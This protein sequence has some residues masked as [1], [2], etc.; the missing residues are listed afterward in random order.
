MESVSPPPE[1][2]DGNSLFLRFCKWCLSPW[3]WVQSG[4][5]G[6]SSCWCSVAGTWL[7]EAVGFPLSSV[8][9]GLPFLIQLPAS[10]ILLI[11]FCGRLKPQSSLHTHNC[12][13]FC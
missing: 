4:H 3:L 8:T 12:S 7:E 1:L 2:Q 6:Q 9:Q 11:Y 13:E 10:E 5:R